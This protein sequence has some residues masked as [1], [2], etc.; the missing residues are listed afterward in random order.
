MYREYVVTE[1][2]RKLIH[3]LFSKCEE[4]IETFG[5]EKQMRHV[6]EE[7][8]ELIAAINHYYRNRKGAYE[9]I[10][11]ELADVIIMCV[12]LVLIT[13]LSEMSINE[14]LFGKIQEKLKKLDYQI[15]NEK[16]Y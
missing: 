7:C 15:N 11:E 12:Q 1:D 6:Q 10:I 16:V 9:E 8:A 14:D 3:A 13:N 2:D 4:A 5:E